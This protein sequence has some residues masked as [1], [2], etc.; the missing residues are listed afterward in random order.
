MLICNGVIYTASVGD[1]RAILC[2]NSPLPALVPC[3]PSIDNEIV[4]RFK[5]TRSNR[6]NYGLHSLQLTKDQK[7]DDQE[8]FKRIIEYGGRVQR[9][10]DEEGNKVGPYR[11]WELETNSPGLTM[12]RS[13]GDLAAKEIGVIS[14]PIITIHA[15][16]PE[17][18]HFIV[19]ASDGIWTCMDNQ[20][21]INFVD[22]YRSLACKEI[23][24]HKDS[25]VN[26][27]NSC[28]AQLLCEEA[29][30]R[31]LTL[32]EEEDVMIDDISCIILELPFN[33][34]YKSTSKGSKTV[35]VSPQK[36]S[37][38]EKKHKELIKVSSVK[39]T[40][41]KDGRRNSPIK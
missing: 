6:F 11:V 22:L 17:R 7:P 36:L 20:D 2:S 40:W 15:I 39:N 28:I 3:K 32:V 8:E 14:A 1:S 4:N 13:I 16:A 24:E 30:A 19:V 18:D 33:P 9:L 35:C 27:N 12:S 41:I 34:Q 21:V 29:R 26:V 25:E 10:I 31:W 37:L 5:V 23:K 38:N